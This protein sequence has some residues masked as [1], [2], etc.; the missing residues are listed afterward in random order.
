MTGWGHVA[1]R[2]LAEKAGFHY[3]FVKQ[4]SVI[5]EDL[6]PFPKGLLVV[7]MVTRC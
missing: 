3:Y 4:A 6:V 5:G 2:A 7:K 1:D